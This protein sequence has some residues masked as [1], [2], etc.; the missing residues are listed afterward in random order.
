MCVC[1]SLFLKETKT[2][3]SSLSELYDEESSDTDLG[4]DTARCYC[5]LSYVV[6]M[7][8]RLVLL[9]GDEGPE[10]RL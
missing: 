9:D 7:M 1:M 6:Y 3:R 2:N 5:T 10:R 8:F 4:W